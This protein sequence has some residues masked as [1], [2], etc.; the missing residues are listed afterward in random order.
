LY[1]GEGDDTLEGGAGDDY[2][3]GDSGN[4]TL[5]G[6]EG[7][8][9]L[10]GSSGDDTLEGGTGDDTLTDTSGGSDTYRYN[11]GDGADTIHE[12]TTS[13]SEIDTLVL[14]PDVDQDD[15]RFIRVEGSK[16]LLLSF[17]DGGTLLIKDQYKP[18][19]GQQSYRIKDRGIEK[20]VFADGT[21]LDANGIIDRTNQDASE[22]RDYL[23]GSALD[24]TIRGLGGNDV[25]YGEGGND[26][27]EGGAGDDSIFGG[28]G[29]DTLRGGEGKDTLYGGEGDDTYKYYLSDGNNT[30]IDVTRI[31]AEVDRLVFADGIAT[32]DLL[33]KLAENSSGQLYDLVISLKN[34]SEIRINDQFRPDTG[35][36]NYG[37]EEVVFSDGSVING[38]GIR[39]RVSKD[40]GVDFYADAIK[41]NAEDNT[42]YS[43]RGEDTL[44]GGLG[45][46][47][48]EG[49]GGSDVYVYK[50]GDG[51]DTILDVQYSYRD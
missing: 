49:Q 44:I 35:T 21:E 38:M 19:D 37:I 8:D 1:G 6:G 10:D 32:D 47:R 26:T 16:D 31:P 24:N 5:R 11:L 34:G 45:D 7:K 20:V 43:E 12:G 28:N 3:R 50:S 39:E 41:G 18:A 15:V 27:L 33:F 2:L 22:E 9:T 42:L 36:T 30:I 23:V 4:D 40:A 25:I 48:L 46:D 17:S 13:Y 51:N 14:G 29:D